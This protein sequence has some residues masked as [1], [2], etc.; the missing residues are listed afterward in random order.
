MHGNEKQ[1]EGTALSSIVCEST[2]IRRRERLAARGGFF[3]LNKFKAQKSTMVHGFTQREYIPGN[4]NHFNH[5]SVEKTGV[6]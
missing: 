5:T 4:I 2:D 3:C 6:N 1:L